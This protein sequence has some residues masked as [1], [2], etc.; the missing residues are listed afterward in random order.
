M[1]SQGARSYAATLDSVKEAYE[2]IKDAVNLT[3]VMTCGAIDRIAGFQI[4]FKCENFQKV[5]AFKFRG[6]T[7][8]VRKYKQAGGKGPLVTHSS[9]NHAQ[10]LA[11]AAKQAGMEAH[12]VMPSNASKPKVDAVKEYGAKVVFCEP[13][14]ADRQRA[15]DE[16]LSANPGSVFVPP[17]DHP[18]IISGAGT[19]ALE[20]LTQIGEDKLDAII[21]PVGGGGMLSGCC[22][23]AKG[24]QPDIRVYAAEPVGA[25]DCA[26]SFR[27]GTFCE[28]TD[29][30]TIADGLLTSMGDLT[31][32]IIQD[33]ITDVITVTEEEIVSAMRLVWMRMKLVIEPSAAVGVGIKRVGVVLCGGN[34]DIDA[35]PW[36]QS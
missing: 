3:P 31:W 6:A 11:L 2:N 22:I 23:A 21:I 27:T 25:D 35:L 36:Q 17:Y 15:A 19:L 24:L 26:K 5:G 12:I 7:N 8:A 4:L 9:G 13:I 14:V 34:V 32:P 1:A 28:Q 33:H 18:D 30:R 16:I 29:P 20:F 10:A